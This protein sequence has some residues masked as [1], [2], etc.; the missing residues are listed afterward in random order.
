MCVIS[1]CANFKSDKMEKFFQHRGIDG[2]RFKLKVFAEL[3]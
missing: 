2:E 1:V 3:C